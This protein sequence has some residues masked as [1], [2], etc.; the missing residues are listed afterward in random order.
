MNCEYYMFDLYGTLIDI[1]TEEDDMRVWQAMASFYRYKGAIYAPEECRRAWKRL[2]KQEEEAA[3]KQ[4]APGQLPEPQ[5]EKVFYRMYAEKG[6]EVSRDTVIDTAQL[7][8]CASMEYIR[9]YDGAKHLLKQLRC[10]GKKLYVLSNAQQVFT[11][12]EMRY[13]GI[14]DA[15]DGIFFSSDYHC[16]KPDP[17]FFQALLTSQKLDPSR[18]M[19]IGNSAR[20]DIATARALGLKT[21]YIQSNLSDS[22]EI[23]KCDIYLAK[24]NLPLLEKLLLKA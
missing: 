16:K 7:F 19:M 18:G 3:A 8:R 17:A 20:D 9:L 2:L 10:S 14:Y 22:E 13:L 23:P 24:M 12:A 5:I 1:H 21:C 4:L 6:A 11:E 15:F